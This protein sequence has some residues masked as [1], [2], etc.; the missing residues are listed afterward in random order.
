MSKNTV[1]NKN[2]PQ[3]AATIWVS[4]EN[5][6]ARHSVHKGFDQARRGKIK[7]ESKRDADGQSGQRF[8]KNG[9]EQQREAEADQNRDETGQSGIPVTC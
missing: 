4:D 2:Y 3:F 6:F 8:S 7:H 1:I 9:Q 5:L